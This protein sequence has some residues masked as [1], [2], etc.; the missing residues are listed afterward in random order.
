MDQ[1]ELIKEFKEDLQ[2][3]DLS[4]DTIVTY[5]RCVKRLYAFTNGNL[6]D[7]NEEDLT[8]YIAYLR[9]KKVSQSSIIKYFTPLNAFYEF[10]IY[11]KCVKTNPVTGIKKRR[12]LRNFKSHDPSQRRQCITLEQAQMLVESIYEPKELAVVV[13]LLKTGIRKKECSEI[14][15]D[16]LDMKN[17]TIHL[18]PT[19]KRSNEVVY[20]DDETAYV[21]DNW[22]KRREKENKNHIQALFLDRFG[23]RLSLLAISRIVEKHAAT[24]GLHNPESKRLEDRLSP[25]SFRHFFTTRMLEAGCPRE[26]VQELRG[27]AGRSAIDIYYHIDKKKLQQSYLDCVP[28]FGLI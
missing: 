16:G 2:V 12:Y 10:L 26:Y 23:N 25:H 27:D 15:I 7:V 21:L 11:K 8:K 6:I 22:L 17:K 28:Q 9:D 1:I 4:K 5:P 24:V 20:F 18:T 13:L 14:N 3:Q 19:K